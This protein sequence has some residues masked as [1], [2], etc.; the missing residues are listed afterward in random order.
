MAGSMTELTTTRCFRVS[1]GSTEMSPRALRSGRAVDLIAISAFAAG[2]QNGGIND[3]TNDDQVLPRQLRQHRDEPAC[4][5]QRP[6]GR[7][8]R[9]FRVRRWYPEWRDQ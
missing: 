7:S 1:C 8:H 5:P 2:I 4:A 3:G 6:R 9:D